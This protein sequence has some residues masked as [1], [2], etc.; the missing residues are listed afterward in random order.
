MRIIP[1]EFR[2]HLESGATTLCWCWRLER[3]DGTVLG[4]TDH[5]RSIEFDGTTY[6]ADSGLSA[7]EIQQSL[8]LN[9][10]NLEV[11]G[12]IASDEISEVDLANGLYDNAAVVIYRVNWA[13]PS[14]RIQLRRGSIGEVRWTGTTFVAEIRGLAH[15]LQQEQGRTYQYTCD[16]DLGDSRCQVS[17]S[18]PAFTANGTIITPIS[19]RRYNVIGLGGYN[20]DWFRD[21]RL[22]WQSGANSG[23]SMEIKVHVGGASEQTVEVWHK[24]AGPVL[25][26]DTFV[27]TAGCDKR[28]ATCSE[29]FANTVNYR[30]FPHMPGNDFVLSVASGGV[31]D[32]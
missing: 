27:V 12:G 31:T 30:G 14:S 13:D 4:F 21:G 32:V 8:G 22:I 6:I 26:G 17:L 18:D 23:A 7:S 5:D 15:H 1:P 16:A 3:R 19:P 29:K 25:A 11:S 2:T 20:S 28:F 24:F 10:D 9:V